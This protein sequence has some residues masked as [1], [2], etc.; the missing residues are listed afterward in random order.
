[1]A[2]WSGGYHIELDKF[3][4]MPVQ[5]LD[6]SV[7]Q[8]GYLI[9]EYYVFFTANGNKDLYMMDLY[10]GFCKLL[11]QSASPITALKAGETANMMVDWG[12]GDMG[13][14]YQKLALGTEDG[15]FIVIDVSP[16]YTTSEAI[17]APVMKNYE[18]G[19][20]KIV[21]IEFLANTAFSSSSVSRSVS[22]K[23]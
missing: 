3:Y 7:V 5:N 1:V 10:R 15:K 4:E 23:R 12:M 2:D 11:Y 16:T 18:T 9:G 8:T 14:Y 21:S 6:Q 19:L 13:P 17:M 22:K 20:G